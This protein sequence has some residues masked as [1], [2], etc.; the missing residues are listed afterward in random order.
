MRLVFQVSAALAGGVCVL[1]WAG[2]TALA[3]DA[4][5]TPGL[6]APSGILTVEV[7]CDPASGAVPDSVEGVSDAFATETVELSRTSGQEMSDAESGPVYR[8]RATLAPAAVLVPDARR[9]PVTRTSQWGVD[10]MCPGGEL[11]TAHFRVD[12]EAPRPSPDGHAAS[13]GVL[14]GAPVPREAAVD[15]VTEDVSE[16]AAGGGPAVTTGPVSTGVGAASQDGQPV[17]TAA[18]AAGS[19]LIIGTV[20]VIVYRRTREARQG[21][22]DRGVE[23]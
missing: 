15:E 22:R 20:S 13:P 6:V 17:S 14:S 8:G 12:H 7:T 9:E 10:G 5:A 11:W 18:L 2:G 4:E 21:R 16:D 3:A 23:P 19:A 1:A